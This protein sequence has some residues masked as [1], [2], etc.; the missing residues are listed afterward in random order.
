MRIRGIDFREVLLER[1]EEFTIATGTSKSALNFVARIET[2][3]FCGLG[4][5]CPS[6]VT[7]ETPDSIRKDLQTLSK[8]LIG[9]EA[10]EIQ[11]LNE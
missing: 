5:C 8:E 10:T 3:D 1:E 9:A 11:A 6:S 4:S 7:G 2:E